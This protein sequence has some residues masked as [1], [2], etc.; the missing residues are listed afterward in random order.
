MLY[1]ATYHSGRDPYGQTTFETRILPTLRA[2]ELWAQSL[3]S[4]NRIVT[5]NDCYWR[6][7]G[8]APSVAWQAFGRNPI[9]FTGS[10]VKQFV[11]G[12]EILPPITIIKSVGEL[13]WTP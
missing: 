11:N 10:P 13:G 3:L 1:R 4:G 5:T 7:V 6:D 8:H 2:V 12:G 9:Q